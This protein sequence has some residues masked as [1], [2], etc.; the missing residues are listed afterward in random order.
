MNVFLSFFIDFENFF[1]SKRKAKGATA[2]NPTKNLT[3]LKVKG[4][5]SSIPVSWAIKVVPQINV[6]SKALNND[7]VFD[8]K[9]YIANLYAKFLPRFSF[10]SLLNLAASAPSIIL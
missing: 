6:Q 4:P 3:A 9:F 1:L 5:I 10:R 8:I 7:A 2:K